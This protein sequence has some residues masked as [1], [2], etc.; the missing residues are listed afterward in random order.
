MSKK[1]NHSTLPR[2]RELSLI[3]EACLAGGL[4]GLVSVCY[5]YSLTYAEKGL[6][7]IL[8]R[9][10]G[11]ML[12]GILWFAVLAL[13]GIIVMRLVKWEGFAGGSGVPQVMAE[14]GDYL[15]APWHRTLI[16]KF[17]CGT[18][19]ILGGLSLGRTGPSVQLG[20]MM[21]KGYAKLRKHDRENELFLLSCGAAA[22]LAATF[23]APLAGLFFMLE[24]IQG[25]LS[26]KLLIGG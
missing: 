7:S 17:I 16:T 21:A 2:A 12:G 3:L 25:K 15:E 22:G 26:K 8:S 14:T 19:G 23:N 13:M 20:A 4:A 6:Y 18:L 24:E 1:I 5:R 10:K 11:H 9:I